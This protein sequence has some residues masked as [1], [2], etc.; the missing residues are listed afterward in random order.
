MIKTVMMV[1]L[2]SAAAMGQDVYATF[3]VKADKEANLVLS[4]TGWSK[5]SMSMLATRLKKDRFF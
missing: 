2:L 1:A 4:L 5:R 3:N